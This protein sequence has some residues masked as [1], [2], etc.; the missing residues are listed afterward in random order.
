MH[1]VEELDIYYTNG[2]D[3]YG[4]ISMEDFCKN[5]YYKST[6]IW[7]EGLDGWVNL[8]D[9]DILKHCIGTMSTSTT[10][11]ETPIAPSGVVPPLDKIHQNITAPQPEDEK[12][13][14]LNKFIIFLLIFAVVASTTILIRTINKRKAK[15][16]ASNQETTLIDS[17]SSV[18][19]VI[20]LEEKAE[21]VEDATKLG[22]QKTHRLNWEKFVLVQPNFKKKDLGGI[23]NAEIVL[24]NKSPYKMDY[25]RVKIDY[26]KSN[27]E[28]FQTK[29]VE[30]HDLQSDSAKT[31]F[32]PDS[33]RGVDLKCEIIEAKSYGMNFCINKD[34][35]TYPQKGED[36]YK[37]N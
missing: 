12:D 23:D 24:N 16:A 13:T 10:P 36:P 19:S 4:P 22:E 30:F 14:K 15:A 21:L 27:G 1:K 33:K 32:A 3:V 25:V 37:C 17:T 2:F 7:H 34:S 18:D 35:K 28:V 6:K 5:K 20:S 9:S 29:N 8:Q 31:L 26:L 11:I